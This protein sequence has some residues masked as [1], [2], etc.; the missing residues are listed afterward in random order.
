MNRII[1]LDSG[2]RIVH[3]Y[4]PN[5]RSV[6]MGVFVGS[7]SRSETPQNSGISHFIEHMCFKGTKGRSAFKIVEEIDGLGAQINAYTS[8]EHTAYYT[9]CIDE[10]VDK[11][12]DILSDIFLNHTFLEEDIQKERGVILEEIAMVKDTPDELSNEL[13]VK[14]YWGDNALGM[15]ILGS[16]KNVKKFTSE[17]LFAYVKDNYVSENIVISFAG[18]ITEEKAVE[19]VKNYF[20]VKVGSVNKSYINSKHK[21]LKANI[22]VKKIE[23][24]NISLVYPSVKISGIVEPALNILNSVYGSGM[25]SILFQK[26]REELGLAYSVY[27]YPSAY[28][29]CGVFS[30]YM[31]TNIASLK[32]ALQA[33]VEINKNLIASGI[34]EQEFLRGKQQ[35]KG[36]YVLGQESNLAIMRA[37]ARYALTDN[38]YF[39]IEEKIKLLNEV[40]NNNVSDVIDAIFNTKPAIGYVGQKLPFNLDEVF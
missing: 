27:S 33:I 12:A 21:S 9:Y 24:A 3:K 7:G 6:A 31:G 28:V 25:S 32:N 4:N 20:H 14:A 26:M 11:C 15:P 40:S 37:M 36:A 22:R 19:I 34:S 2:L 29:D 18:N 17:D 1:N 13:A 8:K 38:K 5:V 39:D 10:Y 16:S 30:V 35:L 23:Q